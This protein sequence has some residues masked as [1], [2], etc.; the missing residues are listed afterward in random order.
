MEYE[1]EGNKV[2]NF[3]LFAVQN[4]STFLTWYL[5]LRQG[6]MDAIILSK[7]AIPTQVVLGNFQD[8]NKNSSITCSYLLNESKI[9]FFFFNRFAL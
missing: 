4:Y 5:F 8:N 2:L 1:T 7:R 3:K 6:I 9:L